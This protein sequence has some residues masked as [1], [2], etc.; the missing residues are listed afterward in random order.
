MPSFCFPLTIIRCLRAITYHQAATCLTCSLP[1]LQTD[2]DLL[3]PLPDVAWPPK[4]GCHEG[5]NHRP[6]DNIPK[7]PLLLVIHTI[8]GSKL[9]S[10]SLP[11]LAEIRPSIEQICRR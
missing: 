6:I 1:I 11:P 3:S 7:T 9:T 10:I 5:A 2:T 8:K 4:S